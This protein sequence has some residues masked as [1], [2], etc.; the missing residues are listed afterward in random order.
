MSLKGRSHGTKRLL[1]LKGIVYNG[2]FAHFPEKAGY[3][4]S[5]VAALEAIDSERHLHEIEPL[6]I[7]LLAD[8]VAV[9]RH[10][11]IFRVGSD[12]HG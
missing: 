5:S 10:F 11:G 3:A 1:G 8:I 7:R 2:G 12:L 4:A 9:V 6:G